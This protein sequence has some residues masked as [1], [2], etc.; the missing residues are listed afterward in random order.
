[1]SENPPGQPFKGRDRRIFL[2]DQSVIIA[3]CIKPKNEYMNPNYVYKSHFLV[4]K[5]A[6]EADVPDEPLRF[7]LKSR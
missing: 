1:V 5:M 2:F 7:V 3:D 6:L 4:N